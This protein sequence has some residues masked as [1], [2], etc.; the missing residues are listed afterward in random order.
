MAMSVT[1]DQIRLIDVPPVGGVAS[2]S[3]PLA[4]LDA[5][6]GVGKWTTVSVT[7]IN[8]DE[9]EKKRKAA[10]LEEEEEKKRAEAEKKKVRLEM[11]AIYITNRRQ[12]NGPN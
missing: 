3:I 2:G 4:N 10:M 7:V 12:T 1:S 11:T 8:E 9:E 6:T 5:N